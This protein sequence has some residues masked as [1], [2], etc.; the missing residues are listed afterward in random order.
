MNV[1]WVFVKSIN[2]KN[3]Q[4]AP[5]LCS[6]ELQVEH[7]AALTYTGGNADEYRWWQ[8]PPAQR[9]EPIYGQTWLTRHEGVT[10]S[11]K[12]AGWPALAR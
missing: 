7:A 12:H 5:M 8:G 1:H 6:T 9:S 11:T 2:L 10:R 3:M 4:L